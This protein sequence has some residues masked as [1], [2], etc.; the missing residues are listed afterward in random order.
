MPRV[1]IQLNDEEMAALKN[2]KARPRS[3]RTTR[4][5]ILGS[6]YPFNC[7]QRRLNGEDNTPKIKSLI[8]PD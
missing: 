6:F 1:S 2:L 8:I 5:Q 7:S 3:S 4:Q